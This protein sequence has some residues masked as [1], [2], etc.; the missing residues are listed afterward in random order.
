MV[1]IWTGLAE[2]D[3]EY[4]AILVAINSMLQMLLFAPLALLFIVDVSHSS[5]GYDVDLRPNCTKCWC[6]SRHT[7]GRSH[8]HSAVSSVFGGPREVRGEILQ[9]D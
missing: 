3:N 2:R 5:A 9:V 4:C 6:F 7:L 1:L 8:C